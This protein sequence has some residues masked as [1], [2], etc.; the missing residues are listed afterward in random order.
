MSA[1]GDIGEQALKDSSVGTAEIQASAVTAAKLAGSITGSLLTANTVDKGQLAL[2]ILQYAQ[3]NLTAA[4]VK[5][6]NTTPIS[7]VAAPGSGLGIIVDFVY[8]S[9]VYV[10]ATYSCNAGGASLFY[11]DGSGTA[12]G[13]ALTQAFIQTSSGTAHL[14]VRGSAT[15]LAPVANAAIVIKAASTD[16]TTGDS[17]IK[18]LTYYRVVA[19][20]NA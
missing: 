8:A 12:V 16:P 2:G 11:T 9:L 20:P 4:Q 19:M 15:A 3:V 1:S 10:S 14:H 17:L 7:L 18:V 5:A 6:L 13:I